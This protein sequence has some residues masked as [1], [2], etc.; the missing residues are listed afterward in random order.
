MKTTT[1]REEARILQEAREGSVAERTR[2][3]LADCEDCSTA[4]R[5]D[6]LLRSDADH[7][8]QL[9]SLPDPTLVWWRSQQY[10]KRRKTERATLPIQMAERL[11]LGLGALGLIIGLSMTWPLLGPSV[12]RWYTG[13]IQGF[14]K[15]LPLEGTSLTLALFCSLFLLVGFGLYSQWAER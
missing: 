12:A 6:R 4:V 8:P 13:W 7:L 5:I 9:D 15:A 10:E 3:H 14:S 2:E 1:C 11:A